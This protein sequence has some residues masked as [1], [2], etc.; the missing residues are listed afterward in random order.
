[1]CLLPAEQDHLL[2]A[3][4][5]LPLHYLLMASLVIGFFM[6]VCLL[7]DVLRVA[8]LLYFQSCIWPGSFSFSCTYT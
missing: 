3:R 2:G 1:M 4:L 5:L 6:L 8:F 7:H